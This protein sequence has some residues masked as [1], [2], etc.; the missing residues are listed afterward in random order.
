MSKHSGSLH[1]GHYVADVFDRDHNKWY[2]C[3]DS[4][5]APT[6]LSS[7]SSSAYVLFYVMN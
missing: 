7:S 1:G 6:S 3:N 5:V 4:N 2:A